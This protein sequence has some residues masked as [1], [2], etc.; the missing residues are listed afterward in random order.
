MHVTQREC[1]RENRKS[2]PR[3]AIGAEEERENEAGAVAAVDGQEA[4]VDAA[5]D[6]IPNTKKRDGE[7][8]GTPFRV[9]VASRLPLRRLSRRRATVEARLLTCCRDVFVCRI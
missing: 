7:C 9:S 2:V 5:T 3:A 1:K 6:G 4:S 8:G